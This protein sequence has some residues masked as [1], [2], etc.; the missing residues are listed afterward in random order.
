VEA[1]LT[2]LVSHPTPSIH[3]DFHFFDA[4]WAHNTPLE[5]DYARGA[6]AGESRTV[7]LTRGGKGAVVCTA[8]LETVRGDSSYCQTVDEGC[9][10]E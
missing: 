4:S 2:L 10:N 5:G 6:I 9:A 7:V 8:K 3:S 1:Y